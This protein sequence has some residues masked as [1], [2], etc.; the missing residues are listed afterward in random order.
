[1]ANTVNK[2]YELKSYLKAS[3]ITTHR[4]GRFKQHLGKFFALAFLKVSGERGEKQSFM[5]RWN[6]RVHLL[7][8]LVIRS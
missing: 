6:L 3:V 1:M 7:T 2:N 4:A 8:Y 5:S